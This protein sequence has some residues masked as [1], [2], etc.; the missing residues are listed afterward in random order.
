M[1]GTNNIDTGS[2]G[3]QQPAGTSALLNQ[4]NPSSIGPDAYF[5][6][7]F[8]L[9]TDFLVSV[10]RIK[11]EKVDCF[12]RNADCPPSIANLE[13]Y[14]QS[15][16]NTMPAI[17]GM[18]RYA[19]CGTLRDIPDNEYGKA[20]MQGCE[21]ITAYNGIP[22]I[23]INKADQLDADELLPNY[24]V[25]NFVRPIPEADEDPELDDIDGPEYDISQDVS[26]FVSLMNFLGNIPYPWYAT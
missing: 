21:E 19:M 8:K 25:P 3:I 16:Q 7:E 23:G 20:N 1:K 6:A 9:L 18:K 22:E 13:T 17:S 4:S 10:P 24:F 2:G 15:H 12:I 14:I 11:Q 26:H 5:R